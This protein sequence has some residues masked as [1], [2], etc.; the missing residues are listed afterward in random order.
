MDY[1]W[2]YI[3]ADFCLR[4]KRDLGKKILYSPITVVQ[5]MHKSTAEQ[6]YASSYSMVSI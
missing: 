6:E 4:L 3:V 5:H 1:E 2:K